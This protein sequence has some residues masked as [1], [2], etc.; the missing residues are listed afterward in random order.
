[1]PELNCVVLKSRSEEH[2]LM[3]LKFLFFSPSEMRVVSKTS[4]IL[5]GHQVCF[6]VNGDELSIVD[7]D[8]GVAECY[9]ISP[10]RTPEKILTF[11]KAWVKEN[12]HDKITATDKEIRLV[13]VYKDWT[14]FFYHNNDALRS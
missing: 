9:R 14:L 7:C 12:L 6:F 4:S 10:D 11:S 13:R 3:T 5:V 1:M 8:T 2:E